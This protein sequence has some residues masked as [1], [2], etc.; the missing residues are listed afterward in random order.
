VQSD[1]DE[2]LPDDWVVLI[3]DDEQYS[4]WH[5]L[6]EI[7]AGWRPVGPRGSKAQALAYIE[8]HWTDMRPKRLRD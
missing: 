8:L 2:L 1:D 3:N 5:A 4:L 6:N 7:P